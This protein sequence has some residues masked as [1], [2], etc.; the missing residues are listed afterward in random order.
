MSFLRLKLVLRSYM[1]HRLLF[2]LNL[3]SLIIGLV[4]CFL[5]GI[6]VTY[7]L[8]FDRGIP[9]YERIYRVFIYGRISDLPINY[10]VTML[11][12]GKHLQ[13]EFPEIETAATL[14]QKSGSR[15][16]KVG[17]REFSINGI[18]PVTSDFCDLFGVPIIA[19][20]SSDMLTEPNTIILTQS[21]A[22]TFFGDE[23]PLGKVIRTNQSDYTVTGIVE[24]PPEN[25]HFSF[26]MLTPIEGLDPDN[27]QLWGRFGFYTY[28][29][30]SQNVDP[31]ELEKK[32]KTFAMDKMEMEPGEGGM[33]F[34][35]GLQPVKDIHLHSTLEYDMALTGNTNYV[36]LFTAIGIFILALACINFAMLITANA[37]IRNREIGVSKVYGASRMALVRQF[38]RESLLLSVVAAL[39]SLLVILIIYPFFTELTGYNQ[40]FE[41]ALNWRIIG[42]GFLLVVVTG[43]FA[44]LYPALYLSGAEP[45]PILKGFIGG[46]KKSGG[47]R[48]FLTLFQFAI[49]IALISG[50]IAIY[51]QLRFIRNSDLGFKKD[52]TL[53]AVLT[54]NNMYELSQRAKTEFGKLS[55]VRHVSLSTGFPGAGAC[56]G[57]G[58]HIEGLDDEAVMMIK[59]IDTD[60]EFID[61]YEIQILEGDTIS[62]D[63]YP[64]NENVLVN[65]ALV[66]E[67]GWENPIGR[68]IR[69]L[70]SMDANG[71]HREYNVIGVVKDFHIRSF[72]ES[73]EPLV[74][75]MRSTV[76][77]IVNISIEETGAQETIDRLEAKWE[78]IEPGIPLQFGYVAEHFDDLHAYEMRLGK[79]FSWFSGLAVMIACLGLFGL[80]SFALKHRVKEIGI[81][82]VLGSTNQEIAFILSR[83]FVKW[84]LLANVIA[85]PISWYGIRQWIRTFC[86]QASLSPW[87]FVISALIVIFISLVTIL[88]HTI[89]AARM[90]PANALK[91]E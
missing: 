59:W 27:P 72:R 35:L 44:G 58:M 81:R 57:G 69:D 9:D 38:L 52:N 89:K 61:T 76:K 62:P 3:L 42:A 55:G 74:L 79:I 70:G 73:I 75:F 39:L 60:P 47:F 1:R 67:V 28:V 19:S 68:K 4:V 12:L 53:I 80:A 78:E 26:N 85:I 25:M 21:T 46:R 82:K 56:T 22:E 13:E 86:F 48:N 32:I 37:S 41:R 34:N 66:K 20:T 23:D 5:I 77:P 54:M 6:F 36:Y 24:D 31:I 7:E 30:L 65:E 33:E 71:E 18:L 64:D 16:L 51:H 63:R 8:S 49:S 45:V 14:Q 91:Y 17:D 15:Q 43:F 50:T 88:F 29:K 40:M 83:D 90:N 84:V 11:P 2:I 10:S 87:I